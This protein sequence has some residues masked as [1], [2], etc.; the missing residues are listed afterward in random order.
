M[1]ARFSVLTFAHSWQYGSSK[2]N[3]HGAEGGCAHPF[4]SAT[5][6]KVGGEVWR[7]VGTAWGKV[8]ARGGG[9]HY[10][11]SPAERSRRPALCC[12]A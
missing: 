10:V 3:C 8:E 12:V 6:G 9:L 1:P 2:K 4:C 7:V 11:L 5:G